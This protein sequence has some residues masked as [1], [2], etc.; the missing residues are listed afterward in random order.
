MTSAGSWLLFSLRARAVFF[1]PGMVF[2]WICPTPADPGLW[3][4]P[5]ARAKQIQQLLKLFPGLNGS[6]G[7]TRGQRLDEQPPEFIP[8][9]WFLTEFGGFKEI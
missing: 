1:Q 2:G 4:P 8:G 3:D 7:I 6:F 5:P 9:M